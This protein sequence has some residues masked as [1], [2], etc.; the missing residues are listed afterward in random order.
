LA[1]VREVRTYAALEHLQGNVIP[2]LYGFYEVL[3]ILRLI[4]LEPVS[5][6]IPE[7]EKINQSLR[8]KIK[9]ALRC[10]HLA[11]FIHVDIAR[12]NFCRRASG[13]VFLVDLGEMSAF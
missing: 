9:T 10:I 13:V 12:H 2:K 6:A 11:G 7:D 4:A 3:G 5:H 1:L 8:T